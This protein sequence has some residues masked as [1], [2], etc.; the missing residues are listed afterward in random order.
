MFLYD[1]QWNKLIMNDDFGSVLRSKFQYTATYTWYYYVW[2]MWF[3]DWWTGADYILS[4]SEYVPT[5][6]CTWLF[7]SSSY[8]NVDLCTN[9]IQLFLTWA[10]LNVPNTTY[11]NFGS[12]NAYWFV[13]NAGKS[14]RISTNWYYL[15]YLYDQY[16]T[17]IRELTNHNTYML[18]S[19]YSWA[20][21]IGVV[22][23]ESEWNFTIDIDELSSQSVSC[24]WSIPSLASAIS[25][26]SYIQTL[27][28]S[29][30]W[31]S[32]SWNDSQW[33]NYESDCL[34]ECNAWYYYNWTTNTCQPA[35]TTYITE[36]NIWNWQIWSCTNIWTSTVWLDSTAYWSYYQWWKT[37]TTWTSSWST[38]SNAWWDVTNTNTAR[39]WPCPS[40]RHVPSV[41]D[42]N[43]TCNY[44]WNNGCD[45]NNAS[46]SLRIR[47]A[48]S[49]P[50][51]WYKNTITWA[52]TNDNIWHYWTS[53]YDNT[54]YARAVSVNNLYFNNLN[55]PS[56]AYWHSVRCLKN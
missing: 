37:V 49:L 7:G 20:Y 53:S 26:S 21:Y 17:T 34:F 54:G 35:C 56:M 3:D 10:S 1:D 52:F 5:S 28:W 6:S 18:N 51:A 24:G 15:V 19:D 47:G 43:T 8:W 50:Y 12:K 40:G 14:Y 11:L 36:L 33:F 27:S 55:A 42:W 46:N 31:P 30:W 32:L 39:Q 23:W 25:A 45:F 41:A 48:L 22:T 2:I 9:Q 13:L 44:L 16:W 38:T 4:I 29:T